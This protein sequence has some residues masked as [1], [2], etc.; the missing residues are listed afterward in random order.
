VKN[1]EAEVIYSPVYPTNALAEFKQMKELNINLPVVCGDAVDGT[2]VLKNSAAEGIMYTVAKINLPD[3]FIAK[4]NSL[5]GFESLKPNT[6]APTGYDGAKILFL[7]IEKAGTTDG[8]KIKE[9]LLRTYNGVSNSIIEFDE[10]RE[11]KNT[12]FE[13]KTVKGG[14]VTSYEK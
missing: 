11:V 6:A 14:K 13:V 12:V 3:E 10:N 5:K 7:A 1:S 2:D 4:I 9:E 8:S